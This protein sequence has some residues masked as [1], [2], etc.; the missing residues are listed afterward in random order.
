MTFRT[1]GLD[2]ARD[3]E[4]VGRG[5]GRTRPGGA[6]G[7][8]RAPVGGTGDEVRGVGTEPGPGLAGEPAGSVGPAGPGYVAG[9]GGPPAGPDPPGRDGRDGAEAGGGPVVDDERNRA[10]RLAADPASR[11]PD[12][13]PGAG[14]SRL[15]TGNT[16]PPTEAISVASAV[17]PA[18]VTPI[19][20][21]RRRVGD[22]GARGGAGP[23]SGAAVGWVS[24]MLGGAAASSRTGGTDAE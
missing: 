22:C 5:L 8:G 23:G 20:I 14:W 1:A 24:G 2:G 13:A 4:D 21:R 7:A 19:Q 18:A 11:A 9:E 12:W 6:P 16:T 15:R 3:R 10:P 17:T